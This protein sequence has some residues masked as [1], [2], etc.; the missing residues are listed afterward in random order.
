MR[1]KTFVVGSMVVL[2]GMLAMTGLA[3]NRI[4]HQGAVQSAVHAAAQNIVTLTGTVASVNMAP[5]R[6]MPSFTLRSD[7]GEVTVLVGPY[8][9][10]MNSKFEIKQGQVLEVKAFQDPQM[11]GAYV[12]SEIKDKS[13]GATLVLSDA[14]GVPQTGGRATGMPHGGAGGTMRGRGMGMMRGAGAGPGMGACPYNLA[15]VDLNTRTVLAG[16]VESVN[17]APG[18]GFPTFALLVGGRRATIVVCPYRSLLQAGFQ[19]AVGHSMVVEAFPLAGT[20]GSYLAAVL[21]NQSTQKSLT[22]RDEN[23]LPLRTKK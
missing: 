7:V 13:T 21:H 1:S 6:G 22:L 20:E 14:A 12:A 2:G 5:G 23:G 10:L 3:Q 18:Q 17:M 11:P 15:N 9:V 16:T 8:W 19:I 4:Q